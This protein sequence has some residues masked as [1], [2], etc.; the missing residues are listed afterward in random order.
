MQEDAGALPADDA[1]KGA[2]NHPSTVSSRHCGGGVGGTGVGDGDGGFVLSPSTIAGH[3]LCS[4]C[5]ERRWERG[6]VTAAFK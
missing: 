6:A 2:K 5:H 3:F 4:S 1:A